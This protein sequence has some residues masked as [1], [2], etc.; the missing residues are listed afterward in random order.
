MLSDICCVNSNTSSGNL[1]PCLLVLTYAIMKQLVDA[2]NFLPHFFVTKVHCFLIKEHVFSNYQL[3]HSS[4]TPF[5]GRNNI[6]V[7][8]HSPG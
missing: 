3:Y 8:T 6:K 5:A 4:G 7:N 2:T 1:L